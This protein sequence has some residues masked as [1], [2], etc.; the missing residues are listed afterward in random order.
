MA[1]RLA[2]AKVPALLPSLP[3]AREVLA[4]RANLDHEP[5]RT[6]AGARCL[7]RAGQKGARTVLHPRR[8]FYAR[9][10]RALATCERQS[11]ESLPDVLGIEH[12]ELMSCPDEHLANAGGRP[13]GGARRSGRPGD[14]RCRGRGRGRLRRW[15]HHGAPG[16]LPS[17]EAALAAAARRHVPVLA[18]ALPEHVANQVNIE[19]GTCSVGRSLAS[20]STPRSRGGTP[21]SRHSTRDF[22][23]PT[24]SRAW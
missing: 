18:W 12:V 10:D 8:G 11:F 5:F 15:R 17:T 4:V 20:A 3:L 7:L 23:K 19:L 21:R 24:P 1:S 14:R 22:A 13:A 6:R 16:S 9:G 2:D